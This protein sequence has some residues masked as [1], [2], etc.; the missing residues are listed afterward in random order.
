MDF[1]WA[2][3]ELKNGN[4]VARKGWKGKKMFI[5]LVRGSTVD[6]NDL[7]NSA[8]EAAIL[9]TELEGGIQGSSRYVCPHIDMKA[10][11]GSL[12]IGWLASQTDLLAIDWELVDGK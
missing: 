8:K 5:Y 12:V 10:A 9:A 2:L 1:S 3:V 6:F 4:K 7:R 11:D